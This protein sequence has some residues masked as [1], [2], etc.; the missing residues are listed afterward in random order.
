M[1]NKK[2]SRDITERHRTILTERCR[3]V[4]E[5]MDG[6]IEGIGRLRSIFECACF[7]VGINQ[8]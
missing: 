4:I 7:A 5:G 3:T 8:G 2:A 6:L 1:F